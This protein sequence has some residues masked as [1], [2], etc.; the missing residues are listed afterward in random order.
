MD[1]AMK[2]KIIFRTKEMY[3]CKCTHVYPHEG[4]EQA[5]R[6]AKFDQRD[7]FYVPIISEITK[8]PSKKKLKKKKRLCV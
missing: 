6:Q 7:N 3:Y 4:N 5:S 2:K 1:V 8:Q